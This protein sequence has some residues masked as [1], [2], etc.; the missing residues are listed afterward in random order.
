MIHSFKCELKRREGFRSLFLNIRKCKFVE[1][2]FCEINDEYIKYLNSIDSRVPLPKKDDQLHNRKYIGI[3][4]T[5]NTINYFVNLSSYKPEKH[6]DMNEG[7]DFLKIGKCAVINLNNMIPVPKEE[8]IEININDEEENYKKLLFRERNIILKRK[9][10]IYKNSKTIYY[11]KLKYGE[12]SGLAK[13][14]C[15]FKALEIAV[16]N[17]VDDKSDSGEKILVGS[18]SS[19]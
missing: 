9:K 10:D 16:Q 11:H 19:T 15:N 5:I 8:I 7:I 18:A 4:F 14:C 12:N 3:L 13:R 6:D 2:R 17:W 1:L